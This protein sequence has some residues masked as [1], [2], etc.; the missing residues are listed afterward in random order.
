MGTPRIPN[1]WQA[2]FNCNMVQKRMQEITTAG[3]SLT[4]AKR[5]GW[6]LSTAIDSY[7]TENV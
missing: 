3:A 5:K 4:A 7:I 1:F 2:F 6:T